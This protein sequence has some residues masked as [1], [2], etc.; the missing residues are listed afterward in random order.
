MGGRANGERKRTEHLHHAEDVEGAQGS[1]EGRRSVIE[2]DNHSRHAGV[3]RPQSE[4][5]SEGR[6]MNFM[7]RYDMERYVR[8]LAAQF[9]NGEADTAVSNVESMSL[10]SLVDLAN[11]LEEML[12]HEVAAA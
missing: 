1:I 7:N 8:T 5:E 4:E 9:V 12:T 11:E 10:E 6:I 3:V 2:L